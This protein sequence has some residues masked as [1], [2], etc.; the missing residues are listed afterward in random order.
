MATYLKIRSISSKTK[1]VR[2]CLC[3]ISLGFYQDPSKASPRSKKMWL[4]DERTHGTRL[5]QVRWC[6][7]SSPLLDYIMWSRLGGNCGG[8]G[9]NTVTFQREFTLSLL[10]GAMLVW[11]PLASSSWDPA[12]SPQSFQS[13]LKPLSLFQSWAALQTVRRQP[14]FFRS[15]KSKTVH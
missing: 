7:P 3:Q 10:K 8:Q 4:L 1:H 9:G 14:V 12:I 15:M 6:G 13:V 11:G 5:P 2:K